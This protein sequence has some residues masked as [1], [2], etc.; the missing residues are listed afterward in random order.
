MDSISI[1]VAD[2]G[3]DP[4]SLGAILNTAE[5]VRKLI[6]RL[7]PSDRLRI[8]YEAGLCGFVLY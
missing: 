3:G 6:A 7:G 4:H 5:A 2:E 8:C 1:A